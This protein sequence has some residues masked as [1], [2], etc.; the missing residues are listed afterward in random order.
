MYVDLQKTICSS[1]T[2]LKLLLT[3]QQ[4]GLGKSMKILKHFAK[5]QYKTFK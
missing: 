5:G 1:K 4:E 2:A 3:A